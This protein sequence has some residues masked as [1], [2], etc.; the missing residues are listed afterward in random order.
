MGVVEMDRELFWTLF[1]FYIVAFLVLTGLAISNM[2]SVESFRGYFLE[3]QLEVSRCR[4]A[5]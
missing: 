5:R 3:M 4:L 2:N 1:V